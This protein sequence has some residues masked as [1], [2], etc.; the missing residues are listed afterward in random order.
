LRTGEPGTLAELV[1]LDKNPLKVDPAAQRAEGQI[2]KQGKPIYPVAQAISK[3]GPIGLRA[4]RSCGTPLDLYALELDVLCARPV[5]PHKVRGD[6]AVA[7]V[8]VSH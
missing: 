2:I 5:F 4:V 7:F 8:P 1:I 6:F 3:G